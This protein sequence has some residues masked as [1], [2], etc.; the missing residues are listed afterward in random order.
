MHLDG[1]ASTPAEKAEV[2]NDT[3]KFAFITD[4]SSSLSTIP[5]LTYPSLLEITITEHGVLT[6]LSKIDPYKPAGLTIFQPESCK[7]W[8]KSCLKRS[9]IFSNSL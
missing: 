2:L 3:F 4:D 5:A 7:N 1:V 9:L 6:S 8:L